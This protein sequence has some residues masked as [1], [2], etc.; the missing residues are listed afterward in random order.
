MNRNCGNER[1]NPIR[2]MLCT[3][4]C[5]VLTLALATCAL[6]EAAM[7]APAEAT[8]SPEAQAAYVAALEQ[9]EKELV[10]PDGTSCG[11]K[12]ETNLTGFG[13]S[14][15]DVDGDG[16]RE[17]LLIC[18]AD[19]DA[20]DALYV[21]DYDESASALHLEL[22]EYMLVRFYDNGVAQAL[23]SHNQGLSDSFWPFSLYRYNAEADEYALA[24]MADAWEK[25][26]APTGYNGA[27][28][29]DDVDQSGAGIVYYVMNDGN[30]NTDHPVDESEYLQWL[31]PFLTDAQQLEIDYW[32]LSDENIALIQ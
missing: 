2:K 29:P 7:E 21:Y 6:G 27:A 4:L 3:L 18:D 28:F 20:A 10:L 23:W 1:K 26:F 24:G 31:N 25:A 16:R 8:L 17:L 11:V 5:I 19:V 32:S 13:F 22:C 15:S 12:G 30:Y 9:W 14:V